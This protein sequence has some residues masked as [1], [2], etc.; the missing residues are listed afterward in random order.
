VNCG[1]QGLEDSS[2]AMRSAASALEGIATGYVYSTT[3][4]LQTLR[5]S[6]RRN[7]TKIT[8]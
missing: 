7:E 5:V 1:T 2:V 6:A 8:P 4:P 3:N